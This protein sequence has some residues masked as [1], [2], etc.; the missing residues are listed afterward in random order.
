MRRKHTKARTLWKVSDQSRGLKD[1]Q[2]LSKMMVKTCPKIQREET[3]AQQIRDTENS[4]LW[5]EPSAG[6]KGAGPD[7]AG[8]FGSCQNTQ[9]L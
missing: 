7:E 6:G 1:E 3:V 9:G 8:K 2:E 4:S 5:L